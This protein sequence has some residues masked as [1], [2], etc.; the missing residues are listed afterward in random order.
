M[1]EEFILG[2]RDPLQT[3][4]ALVSCEY[5]VITQRAFLYPQTRCL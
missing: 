5:S 1:E 4:L 3:S 2:D